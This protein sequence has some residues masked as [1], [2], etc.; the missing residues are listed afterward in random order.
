MKERLINLLWLLIEQGGRVLSSLLITILIVNHLG[1]E[2][3]GALSLSLAVLTAIGAV[4]GLG[5]DPILFKRFISREHNEKELLETSCFLRLLVSV[6]VIILITLLNLLT[7]ELYITILNVLVIGFLF[8]SFLSVKDYFAAN[9]KNKFYAYSALI[10]LL[11]QLLLVY[12]LVQN[13]VGVIYFT[14]A[15]LLAKIVQAI[16]LYI[17]YF[18]LKNE[19]IYPR[20]NKGLAKNLLRSSFPM[21]LA[22]S[23]GLL[24]SLQDQFFIKYFLGEYELGLY[25]VG[26]KFVLIL[27]VLPTLISNVFYPSLVSKFHQK[28][29]DAYIKQLGGIYAVFFVVGFAAFFVVFLSSEF[30]VN[31]LFSEA[32]SGSIE[33]MEIYSLLLVLAFFQSINNKVL[34]LH[35]LESIIFKRALLALTINAIL[36]FF[37]IPRYGILGAAYSTILSELFV[38]FSYVLLAETRFIFVNQVKAV[39]LINLFKSD[40][41][42]NLKA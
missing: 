8:D 17:C 24:Y 41:I 14:F 7:E 21:M 31:S 5:M 4:V 13:E 12:V 11:A 19:L 28:N 18:K 34:V 39:L 1:P 35:N 32:F 30:I 42:R 3:Y 25:A 36:N 2:G 29:G 26:I 6:L 37:L 15:Y 33:V 10:S 9:L 22:A 40:L 27:I 20:L 23:V 16:S 38:L